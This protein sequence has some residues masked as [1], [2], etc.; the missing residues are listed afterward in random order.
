MR[1]LWALSLVEPSQAPD[2]LQP[3]QPV[4]DHLLK[5]AFPRPLEVQD[6]VG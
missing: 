4:G 2:S 1:R 3:V 6:I 5:V